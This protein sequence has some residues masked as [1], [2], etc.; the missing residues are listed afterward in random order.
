LHIFNTAKTVVPLLVFVLFLIVPNN[1]AQQ[2]SRDELD[3]VYSKFIQVSAPHLLEV[4]AE[5]N[6]EER[7]CGLEII[8][9]VKIN[10]NSFSVEQQRVLKPL[11]QRPVM[12]T[13]IVSQS[14]FFRIHYDTAGVSIPSY[15]NNASIETNIQEVVK[16]LDS[17]Y[18]FEV[19][20]L[21][22]PVPPPDGNEG[23]DNLYDVYIINQPS[24][25][26]GFTLFENEIEPGSKKFTSY[27]VID[28]NYT[29]YP[30]E[31]VYGLRITAA[32]EFHHAIQGGNYIYRSSDTY[33]HE[34]TS[35][36]FEEFVYDDVNDYL[37]Y[38]SSYFAHPDRPM[39]QQSG[40]NMAIWNIYLKERFGFDILK[41]QWELMPDFRAITSINNSIINKGSAFPRELNKFGIWTY[42][43]N[44]RTI[45]GT[46][47]KDAVNF[48]LITLTGTIQFT[49]PSEPVH[50][51]ANP[52]TNNFIKFII[53]S[54]NDTLVSIVSNGDATS[55][56]TDLSQE[57]SFDYELFNNPNSGE[58]KL[59]TIYSSDFSVTEPTFWSVS[60][61]LNNQIVL[62]D[63]VPHQPPGS[64]SYA[65]P[66][67]FTYEKNYITG[68]RIF[69]PVDL[70]VGETVDFNVYSVGM[71]LFYSKE[72]IIKILP[73]DQKGV[74]WNGF[75]HDDNK[76]ASGVYIYVI[77]KGDDI[78]KGKV[79]IFNE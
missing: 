74:V 67:P 14:G 28:N 22:Y 40:Y 76:L 65:Y 61:I 32:H 42:F 6:A 43:T 31:G 4:P 63:T 10:F 37:Q 53:T 26:Y 38:L 12:H 25:L 45:P 19:D 21:G 16:T 56:I 24:S 57:I 78:V 18:S 71:Q 15:I 20:Y 49:P 75:D 11:L 55:A 51:T 58:R 35:T 52:I 47:F 48:P 23:G 39:P 7:K 36:A 69:L 70:D 73:G 66:N 54:S 59:T 13:S 33:F 1:T 27:F 77:K 68:A 79:V 8:N 72:E 50:M 60:E 2:L 5:L 30:S 41:L 9:R 62:E 29:G 46:Y 64:I 44:Y 17:T 34:L 3:S